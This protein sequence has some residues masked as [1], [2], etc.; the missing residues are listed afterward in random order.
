MERGI[1]AGGTENPRKIRKRDEE[2][3]GLFRE[4]AKENKVWVQSGVRNN[5]EKGA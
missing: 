5:P 2:G 1:G 4:Q 3:A